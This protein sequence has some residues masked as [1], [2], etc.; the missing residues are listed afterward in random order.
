MKAFG[1]IASAAVMAFACSA[2][3]ATLVDFTD[4]SAWTAV[5]GGIITTVDGLSVSLQA[6]G[7]H[8]ATNHT[9]TGFDGAASNCGVLAC[10]SDGIG[11]AD[12][13]VSFG[14]GAPGEIERL[15]VTFSEAVTID[16]IFFLD[17]FAAVRGDH[18]AAEMAYVRANDSDV[19]WAAWTGTATDTTGLF[20]ATASNTTAASHSN[21]LI[22]VTMLDF[23]TT[24]F[25][26][27][28]AP[29]NSDFALAGLQI[30]RAQV[31]EPSS[32]ALFGIALGALLIRRRSITQRR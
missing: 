22:N 24:D 19:A 3:N 32:W 20:E 8:G 1:H 6:Y 4:R 29:A 18:A 10:Q 9:N 11:I 17:L 16:S 26:W 13:E 5:S 25:G 28:E 27:F 2:A 15:R 7:A 12:D 23:F 31:P 14:A 21:A 30:R